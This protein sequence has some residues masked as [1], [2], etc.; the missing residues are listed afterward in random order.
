M[1]TSSKCTVNCAGVASKNNGSDDEQGECSECSQDTE[2]YCQPVGAPLPT[3]LPNIQINCLSDAALWEL[4]HQRLAHPGTQVMEQAHKDVDGVPKL[5]G[6]AFYRCPSCMSGKLCTKLPGY[7]HMVGTTRNGH[8]PHT[9]EP[10]SN[11]IEDLIDSVYLKDAIPGQHF[12]S[13]IRLQNP[14][15]E[16]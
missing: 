14:N 9:P 12:R 4:W 5:R 16:R 13:W 11:E 7:H 6:N 3:N 8:C 2:W 15:Q 1:P 10:L